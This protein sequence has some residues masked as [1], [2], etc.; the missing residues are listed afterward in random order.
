MAAM[1]PQAKN[2]DEPFLVNCSNE[3]ATQ[4]QKWVAFLSHEKNASVKTVDAYQRDITQYLQHLTGHLGH[5]PELSD[6][7][8][9]RPV[10]LRGF[11]SRRRENGVG[12]RSLARGL[13]G[14]RSFIRYLEQQGLATSAGLG[15]VATPRLPKTLPR[16]IE[17]SQAKKLVSTDQQLEEEPWVAARNVAALTL[18]YGCGLRISEALAITHSQWKEQSEIALRI[19]GK[20]SK[21]RLVPILPV[22]AEAIET[23]LALCPYVIEPSQTLFRGVRGGPLNP[24]VLQRDMRLLR[25]AMGLPKSATPHALRHSFATHLLGAGGD[26][27]T[28]QELLGHASLSTTQVYTAVNADQLLNIFDKAHPRAN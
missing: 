5:P 24:A 21:E 25:G 2:Q 27:R 20:G 8:D 1:N 15:A 19:I 23:Y 4:V 18:M 13:S 22:V 17:A 11:M 16:P 12:A 7:A 6:L 28:I 10:D 3:L 26:L 9:L 14:I